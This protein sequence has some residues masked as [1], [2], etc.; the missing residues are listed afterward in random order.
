MKTI[1]DFTIDAAK[2]PSLATESRTKL[3]TGDSGT[4]AKWF[5]DKGYD[6]SVGECEKMISNKEALQGERVGIFW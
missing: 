5:H 3:A 4:L 1:T 2:D 6:V